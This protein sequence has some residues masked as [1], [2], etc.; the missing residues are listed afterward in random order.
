[1]DTTSQ[2][3][4][5]P[6]TPETAPEAP[7]WT[8]DG[9]KEPSRTSNRTALILRE[10]LTPPLGLLKA[11]R[12]HSGAILAPILGHLGPSWP[13]FGLSWA[14]LAANL[15]LNFAFGHLDAQTNSSQNPIGKLC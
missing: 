13:L 2:P 15:L 6:D 12:D 9:P 5:S 7:R 11:R 8:Q 14:T 3:R 1:M 4:G 10:A